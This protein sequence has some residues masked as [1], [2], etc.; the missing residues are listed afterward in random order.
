MPPNENVPRW[1]RSQD[2]SLPRLKHAVPDPI[3]KEARHKHAKR[4]QA[5]I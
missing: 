1:S 2:F 3:D 4:G 5:K